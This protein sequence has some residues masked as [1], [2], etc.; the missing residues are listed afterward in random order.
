MYV[1]PRTALYLIACTHSRAG[2]P[3]LLK[4]KMANAGFICTPDEETC[5]KVT[6]VYCGLELGMWEPADDPWTVHY[7][8]E[9]GCSFWRR[10]SVVGD[11]ISK[12]VLWT[13]YGSPYHSLFR[14]A[15]VEL[16]ANLRANFSA[17]A[18]STSHA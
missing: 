17:A 12:E 15:A 8:G 7:E 11:K 14:S 16:Q 10:S 4:T 2:N 5:D 9:P 18:A 6:C 3:K 13:G 1:Y